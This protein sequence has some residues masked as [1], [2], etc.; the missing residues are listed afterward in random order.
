[1]K[2]IRCENERIVKMLK[3]LCVTSLTLALGANASPSGMDGKWKV[4][5]D[6][7]KYTEGKPPKS[8]LI[9]VTEDSTRCH[10][11]FDGVMDDDKA[12]T[13]DLSFP[14][15]GG[16]VEVT[17]A[18]RDPKVDHA[19]IKVVSSNKWIFSYFSKDDKLTGRRV[20]TS[21]GKQ[22]EAKFFEKTPQG[23]KL[24]VDEV[25]ELQ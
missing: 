4:N 13:M 18:P 8:L 10:V 15:K 17:G 7:S 1:M 5:L 9:T 11:H 22:S 12:F 21:D 24:M 6:K 3:L 16:P 20:V 14:L 2:M 25:S 19:S 23:E